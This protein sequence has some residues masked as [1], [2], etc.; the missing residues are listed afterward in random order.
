MDNV[1]EIKKNLMNFLKEQDNNLN[2]GN[3]SGDI[4][5]RPL[6]RNRLIENVIYTVIVRRMKTTMIKESTQDPQN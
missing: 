2:T 6:K 3:I 4:K 5:I 1:H